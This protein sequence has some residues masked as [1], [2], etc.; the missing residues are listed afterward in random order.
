MRSLVS[1]FLSVIGPASTLVAPSDDPRP[2]E[3]RVYFCLRTQQKVRCAGIG[4]ALIERHT[5]GP[6]RL[7]CYLFEIEVGNLDQF[8]TRICALTH[9]GAPNL[10]YRTSNCSHRSLGGGCYSPNHSLLFLL[11]LHRHRVILRALS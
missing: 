3:R 11:L 9:I 2:S 4:R 8:L 6:S 10:I 5:E 1:G 7:S